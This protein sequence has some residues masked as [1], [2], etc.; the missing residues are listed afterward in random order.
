[1][2]ER[3][4]A[5]GLDFLADALLWFFSKSLKHNCIEYDFNE[6]VIPDNMFQWNGLDLMKH[7]AI[8]MYWINKHKSLFYLALQ[9]ITTIF[10][11]S[12]IGYKT[13]FNVNCL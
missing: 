9:K 13:L 10:L 1:M 12:K 5:E 4:R 6:P 3:D 11:L 8:V 2:I 7:S